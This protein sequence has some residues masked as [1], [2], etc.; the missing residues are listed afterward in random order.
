V[1]A[2]AL[3][4]RSADAGTTPARPAASRA[5]SATVAPAAARG[6]PAG[7]EGAEGVL[8]AA[9]RA[10]LPA[11]AGRRCERGAPV[12]T[13][14]VA[15]IA[16]DITVNRY[17]DHDPDGRMYALAADVP[18]VRAEEQRN[19]AARAGA[20]EPGV[21]A[22]LGGD[23]I[24]PLTLRVH[25][26]ECL[27]IRL[28]N[29]L[30]P[31]ERASIHLHGAPLR[32][33]SG[34]PAIATNRA[35]LARPGQTV[36]Y[37]W[38]VATNEP[39]GTR[40]F[41][42]HG[43]D[44]RQSDHGLF[45]AVIVEPRGSQWLDPVTS[46][47]ITT[48]WAAVIAAPGARAFREFALYYHEIG[49]E[50]Y[51][52]LQRDG[53][54]VPLVD[55]ITSAYRPDG[56]ALNY[57]SEPFMHRLAQQRAMGL[58]VDEATEYSSYSYGD[59][60]TP[61]MRTYIGDPVKE[62]VIHGGG[63]VFHVHHVHGGSVR[64]LRQPGEEPTGL[65]RGLDKHPP[66][67]P[68]L[69]ERTDSQS[70]G[71]SEVFDIEHECGAGGCQQGA[72]DYLFHCHVGQHY[73]AGMWGIWRVYNTAQVA[74]SLTDTLGPLARL[75]DNLTVALPAVPSDQLLGS[76]VTAWGASATL[77]PATLA[78]W[79]EP[80]LPPRGVARPGD[81]AVFDWARDGDRY[82]NEP[83]TG[84]HWPGYQ[85]QAPG[86]RPALLFDPRSGRLAYP[87]L[88]PH[89]ARRPPFAPRHGPAPYLEGR[90]GGS[91]PGTAGGLAPAAPGANG[92]AS[93]CPSGTRARAL[94][95]HAID[96][97]VPFNAQ[98]DLI[99]SR[100]EL[101]VLAGDADAVR[102][103]PARRQPLTLRAAAGEECLDVVL[104]S[105]IADTTDHPFSKVSAHIHFVQFDVQGSDGVD[106]GFNY[107]QSVRPFAAAGT[108]VTQP[109]VA[110]AITAAVRDATMFAP[111]AVVGVGMQHDDTFEAA[112]I[113]S[114]G[115]GTLT[116]TAPLTHTHPSDDIVST[117][118]VRYRWY[119][120]AQ[121]GT[122]YFHDHVDGLHS[123][124]H[125]LVG[126]LI[127]EPPG[128]TWS[129]PQSG[130]VASGPVADIRT[131]R[132]VSAE[133]RGSFRELVLFVQDG[134]PVDHVGRSTGGALNLRSEPLAERGGPPA[135]AFNSAAH[136]DPVTP[137]LDAYVGDPFVVRTL[138]SGTNEVHTL[139]VDGHAFRTEPWSTTSPFVSTVHVGISERYDLVVPAAGGPRQQPGDY[140][141]EDGRS[142][143][144]REGAWGLVRVHAA[145]DR[146]GPRPLAGRT[147][148]SGAPLPVCPADAPRKQFAVDAIDTT[149]PLFMGGAGK[150]FV[151]HGATS[152]DAPLVL[153]VS[154]GDCIQV[155][156]TNRT[157]VPSSFHPD[158]LAFDPA[159]AGLAAGRDPDSSVAPGATGSY[160]FYASPT[161]GEGAAIV[162]DGADLAGATAMG[163]YGAIVVAA[164]GARF[165]DPVTGADVSTTSAWRADVTRRDGRAYR[166]F[167]LLFHDADEGIGT[168]RMPYSEHVRNEVG[169]NYHAA[170]LGAR[171]LVDAVQGP[172]TTPRLDAYAGDA[173]QIHVLAP[174]SEQTQ[175]FSI[176]GH[177]WPLE[178]NRPGSNLVSSVA[179]GG[180]AAE[181][182]VPEGGAGGSAR[183]AGDYL[184]GDHREPFRQAG[185]WGL[186]SVRSRCVV[187]NALRPLAGS[188]G[189]GASAAGATATFGISM[190]VASAIVGLAA[191]RRR[192]ATSIRVS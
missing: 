127:A 9:P 131:D 25:P 166:D 110:G 37:E 53:S 161:I 176:E 172:V 169:V 107:E 116:F 17:L 66:L 171:P 38:M 67:H 40:A 52:L 181:T 109:A 60:A 8:L 34:G 175:V 114:V 156:F 68:R 30:P 191:R 56:R 154:V 105:E 182:V 146:S 173:V 16:V 130:A 39:E 92:A 20:G 117:E 48:G 26:G 178:P 50:N 35:A 65:A 145:G 115:P 70:L 23:A 188:S 4:A 28:R 12:R 76:T 106:T 33:A 51:Q 84:D 99:D 157:G 69:S 133:V 15:A 184:Y 189:C 42:S 81:A 96:V 101:F 177:R 24:Q 44:R 80:Q 3:P 62:R 167:T 152:A 143:K 122:A 100:G 138:V 126:A 79:I 59:P 93:L 55:P 57:R 90:P 77:T 137:V 151:M 149:L 168:H 64:W 63:E 136:G 102:A 112:T 124:Q 147:P 19:A 89:L 13:Y 95:I 118:F 174:A 10:D 103:D 43:D 121:F 185:M 104:A 14:D 94:N 180:L 150:A 192:R 123:W 186:F 83:E 74:D 58:P 18:R 119:P 132:P 97:P 128:A 140:L 139:H 82:L 142:F 31:G 153:H 54:Y 61:I 135:L 27:R 111:G 6:G 49:H 11:P 36:T 148:P 134:N 2:V 87:F 190:L 21:S 160:E 22:G 75:P 144:L 155:A 41:H 179:L 78:G 72:G 32:V 159:H 1:Q 91:A 158:R 7:H 46:K 73:F 86:E 85:P 129:D 120:D 88:R 183:L 98:Q 29:A 164:R 47:P 141:I 113:A 108:P 187:T 5:G 163:R 71:P 125:G 162:R 170:P 165:T 45:G